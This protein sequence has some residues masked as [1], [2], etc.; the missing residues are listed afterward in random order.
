MSELEKLKNMLKVYTEEAKTVGKLKMNKTIAAKI[1]ETCSKCDYHFDDETCLLLD[2]PC[3]QELSEYSIN[4]R[5]YR[6]EVLP[7]YPDLLAKVNKYNNINKK[8]KKC[9]C[10]SED[11]IPDTPRQRICKKCAKKNR[12]K[13]QQRADAKRNRK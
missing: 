13:I 11:F 6:A 5:V 4:C 10:C 7:Q 3:A 2:A 12:A 9:S 1:H 8:T